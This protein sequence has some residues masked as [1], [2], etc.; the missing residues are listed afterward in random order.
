MSS[1]TTTGGGGASLG[2]NDGRIAEIEEQLEKAKAEAGRRQVRVNELELAKVGLPA[3][4]PTRID[5]TDAVRQ[6]EIAEKRVTDLTSEL[7]GLRGGT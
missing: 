3:D 2:G 1:T 5:Y 7:N 4:H 6:Q